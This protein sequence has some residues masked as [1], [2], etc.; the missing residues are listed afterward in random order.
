VER[1]FEKVLTA[2]AFVLAV[3]GIGSEYSKSS[4]V[5]KR[6]LGISMGLFGLV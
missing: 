6:G 4:N 2:G 1:V 3:A 5:R